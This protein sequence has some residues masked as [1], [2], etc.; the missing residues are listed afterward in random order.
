MCWR[1]EGWNDWRNFQKKNRLKMYALRMGTIQTKRVMKNE[2]IDRISAANGMGQLVVLTGEWIIATTIPTHKKVC[3]GN[4]RQ[5]KKKKN[6]H[7]SYMQCW[8][9]RKQSSQSSNVDFLRLFFGVALVVVARSVRTK[10]LSPNGDILYKIFNR[11]REKKT[12]FTEL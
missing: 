6:Q 12:P 11:E 10:K 3:T 7:I 9:Y 8:K 2:F 1:E 4:E 5:K